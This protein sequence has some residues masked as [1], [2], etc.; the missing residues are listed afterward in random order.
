MRF[1][2]TLALLLFSLTAEAATLYVR[3][4]ATGTGTGANW[5]NALTSIPGT[6]SV[7]S[8]VY[9]VADGTYAGFR[10]TAANITVRKCT[11]ALDS[12]VAGYQASFCDEQASLNAGSVYVEANG[13]NFLLD[14]SYRNES[15][16]GQRLSYGFGR[17]HSIASNTFQHSPAL[18]PDGVTARYVDFGIG[19]G[20]T[21]EATNEVAIYMGGFNDNCTNWTVGRS[22]IHNYTWFTMVQCAGC[23]TFTLEYS[24]LKD[25]WGKEAIRGQLTATNMIVRY[26][27][28]EDACGFPTSIFN[29]QSCDGC[30]CTAEIAIWGHSGPYDNIRIYG[31]TFWRSLSRPSNFNDGGTI[32]L[33]GNGTSW[34]GAPSNNC[35][36]YNNTIAGIQSFLHTGGSIIING[37]SGN[38]IRNTLWYDVGG[39]P[40][41]QGAG[42]TASNNV[43]VTSNPFVNYSGRDLRLT[44]ATV[45][46]F[47]LV[48]PY[49][50]DQQGFVR[51]ADG[52][53]DIGAFEYDS[54]TPPDAPTNFRLISVALWALLGAGLA[55]NWLRSPFSPEAVCASY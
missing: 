51:G 17:V 54:V 23:D 38:E 20:A 45:A 15:D 11:A 42:M 3:Q 53:W 30:G 25:G 47:A 41:A 26:N 13:T 18:C 48:A 33:G 6:L 7:A 19:D 52:V 46:G 55:T 29:G 8:N 9:V 31:N 35:K 2:F 32:V 27:K 49:T 24:L 10:V 1:L 40:S 39:N 16:W 43:E 21:N 28:F 22:F 44:G 5:T 14:G 37:G 4:G 36:V 34:V 50:I 12:G